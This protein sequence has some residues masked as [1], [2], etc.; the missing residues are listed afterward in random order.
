VYRVANLYTP[1]T[2]GA[3][4]T[5]EQHTPTNGETDVIDKPKNTIDKPIRDLCSG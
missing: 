3:V 1:Y 5:N 4:P 2:N